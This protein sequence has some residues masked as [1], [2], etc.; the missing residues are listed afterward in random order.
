MTD[1]FI[2]AQSLTPKWAG[3]KLNITFCELM[4]I[5]KASELENHLDDPKWVDF[6]QNETGLKAEGCS[7]N[8]QANAKGLGK[9]A[10]IMANKGQGLMSEKTWNEIHSEPTTEFDAS[11]YML[12]KHRSRFTKGGLCFHE[13]LPDA[14]EGEKEHL[15]KNREGFYGWFGYGGSIFQWNP[16]LK[17]GFEFIQPVL[18]LSWISSMKEEQY[19]NNWSKIV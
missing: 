12:G 15:N 3:K 4:K 17:I 8:T 6:L 18:I 2:L 1:G 14:N 5:V 13:N 9:L 16:E 11:F 10:S 19:Y 7:F